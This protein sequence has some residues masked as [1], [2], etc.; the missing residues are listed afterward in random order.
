[1]FNLVKK[2]KAGQCSARRCK[3]PAAITTPDG[4]ELC[5]KHAQIWRQHGEPVFA[6]GEPGADLAKMEADKAALAVEAEQ[7]QRSVELI[8]T[9][10][11]DTQE[12]LDRIGQFGAA[13]RAK[14]KE[15]E[16][17]RKAATQ[18]L[19]ASL[20]EI[21]SWFKPAREGLELC[22]QAL[23]ARLLEAKSKAEQAQDAALAEVEASGG[24]VDETTLAVAHATPQLPAGASTRKVPAYEITDAD[25]VPRKLCSPDPAKIKLLAATALDQGV[26]EVP[27]IRFYYAEIVSQRS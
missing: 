8:K 2:P 20:R 10:P 7:A 11:I 19:N 26:T 1:M 24:Q 13:A 27:G 6:Q 23:N 9:L 17:K 4:V 15:L 21:N 5:E 25:Q 18:P 16:A 12:D 14:I 3:E 22:V